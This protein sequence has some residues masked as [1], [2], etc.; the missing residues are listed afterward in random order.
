MAEAER[1]LLRWIE[2]DDEARLILAA[3]HGST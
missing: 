1:G 3:E 2:A